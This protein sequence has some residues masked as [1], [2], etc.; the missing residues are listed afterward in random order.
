MAEL[1]R[2]AAMLSARAASPGGGTPSGRA[3]SPAQV[4]A[5]S[6]PAPLRRMVLAQSAFE[7]RLLARRGENLLVT[8]ALPVVLLMFFGT[9][10][11]GTDRPT[12]LRS[13][14][15]AVVAVAIVATSF[16]NLGI[17]TAFERSQAVLK[18]LGGSP[19]PRGGLVAAKLATVGLVE[20]G[21]VAL[22]VGVAALLGWRPQR[23]V[24]AGLL[25]AAVTLGTWAF[26]SLGLLLAGLLR[27]E[28]ALAVVNGL[29]VVV[30]LLG[31]AVVPLERL[32]DGLRAVAE[33]LPTAPLAG[34]LEAALGS[35]AADPAVVGGR[36]A[37]LA[38]WAVLGSAGAA[39]TFHWE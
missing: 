29:F 16:V 25:V 22:L 38:G 13:L 24:E 35:A 20:A 17:A 36:L 6:P 2:D 8:L 14:L 28:T 4:G 11:L 5:P 30:L 1:P 31:G 34:A 3:A 10:P 33:L 12:D 26:A 37:V 27:A 21:Q 18:R 15:P 9:V 7:L 19:L 32:P 39:R 23:P